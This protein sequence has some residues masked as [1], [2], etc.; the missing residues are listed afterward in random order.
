MQVTIQRTN[1]RSNVAKMTREQKTI[2]VRV[3]NPGHGQRGKNSIRLMA[4][5]GSFMRGERNSVLR[6][7]ITVGK[8]YEITALVTET[9]SLTGAKTFTFTEI[10]EVSEVD[11]FV[12][13]TV[14]V[15]YHDNGIDLGTGE[16]VTG[17]A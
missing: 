5:N 14:V 15:E 12:P 9:E 7:G 4:E 10:F 2:K 8:C 13:G 16:V 3:G 6:A 17:L 11:A 1:S